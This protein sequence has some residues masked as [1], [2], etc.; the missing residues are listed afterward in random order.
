M[1][2]VGDPEEKSA[3]LL[4]LLLGPYLQRRSCPQ[5]ARGGPRGPVVGGLGRLFFEF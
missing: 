1:K 2:K 4:L 5:G 3:L